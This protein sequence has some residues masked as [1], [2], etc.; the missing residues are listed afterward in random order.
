MPSSSVE[1]RQ[2][3]LVILSRVI[4]VEAEIDSSGGHN[5]RRRR[6]ATNAGEGHRHLYHY[7]RA[8]DWSPPDEESSPT[9]T[10]LTVTVLAVRTGKAVVGQDRW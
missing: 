6:K 4:V 10:P 2:A 8:G 9:A 3:S 5:S 1:P 7:G